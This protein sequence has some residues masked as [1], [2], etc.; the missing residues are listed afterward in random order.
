[1]K[2]EKCAPKMI[3]IRDYYIQMDVTLKIPSSRVGRLLNSNNATQ[4]HSNFV[5]L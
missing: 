2:N 3:L 4:T 1:M 5:K